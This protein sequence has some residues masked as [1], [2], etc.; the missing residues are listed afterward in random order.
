MRFQESLSKFLLEKKNKKLNSLDSYLYSIILDL[1]NSG[2][3][4]ISNETL[5]NLILSLPGSTVLNKPQSYH[6]EEFGTIS[7]GIVTK[8]CEDKFG[9]TRSHDGQ[10]RYLVF[11]KKT[12]ENLKDNYSLSRNI[13]ILGNATSNTNTANTFNTFWKGVEGKSSSNIGIND[14]NRQK[15]THLA[16]K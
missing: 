13:V 7:K 8:I 9:A 4:E 12:I 5:W 6:T 1:T 2:N 3:L 14:C 11:N 15:N 16:S 10:K